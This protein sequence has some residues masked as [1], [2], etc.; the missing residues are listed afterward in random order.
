[1]LLSSFIL[2]HVMRRVH[3]FQE[4]LLQPL[5]YRLDQLGQNLLNS[6]RFSIFWCGFTFEPRFE[7]MPGSNCALFGCSTSRRHEH[8]LF[9]IPTVNARDSE[10]TA[11]SKRKA[12]EEWLRLVLRTREMDAD[13]KQQIEANNIY[14]C[15]L[16]FKPECILTSEYLNIL[17]FAFGHVPVILYLI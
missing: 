11:A 1:M 8:S 5:Y 3:G 6:E 7:G 13:L 14:I 15:E 16:H 10:H 9:K 2:H 4:L 17:R 12:R